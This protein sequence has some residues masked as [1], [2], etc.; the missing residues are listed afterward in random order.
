MIDNALIGDYHDALMGL[1]NKV[2][3]EMGKPS[4][5]CGWMRMDD[6]DGGN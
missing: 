5:I 6:F 1:G 2:R 4:E 3:F